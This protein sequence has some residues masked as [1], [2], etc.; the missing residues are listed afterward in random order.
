ML[1]RAL[2]A[3]SIRSLPLNFYG[4]GGHNFRASPFTVQKGVCAG[5]P[6][7][8][9]EILITHSNAFHSDFIWVWSGRVIVSDFRSNFFPSDS[10]SH[11]SP[12]PWQL[13]PA[14]RPVWQRWLN[15]FCSE[16]ACHLVYGW[17]V[18]YLSLLLVLHL[19]VLQPV[20]GSLK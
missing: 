14:L 15:G 12:F 4:G 3:A 11:S 13:G 9:V 16:K 17:A 19:P 18:R 5:R 1:L 20:T 6:R 8:F 10:A 7:Q 2:G